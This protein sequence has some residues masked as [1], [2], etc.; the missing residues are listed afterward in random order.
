MRNARSGAPLACHCEPVRTLV[1][2][3][4]ILM[5]RNAAR[6]V[7]RRWGGY[8]PPAQDA[9][10]ICCFSANSIRISRRG[11]LRPPADI[12]RR[13]TSG[14]PQVAPTSTRAERSAP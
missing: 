3:S 11:G 8:H 1:W 9:P 6:P 10:I 4:V 12:C 7:G 13:L 2:Q 14:R 5:P